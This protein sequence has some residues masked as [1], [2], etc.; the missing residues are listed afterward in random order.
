M[1]FLSQKFVAF[2]DAFKIIHYHE[3]I[4]SMEDHKTEIFEF[5]SQEN[6]TD[7]NT[8]DSSGWCPIQRAIYINNPTMT[9]RLLKLWKG[10]DLNVP[11]CSKNTPLTY[12]ISQKNVKIIEMLINFGADL[13]KEDSLYWTPLRKAIKYGNL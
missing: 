13:N 8:I 5:L 2:K 9:K 7:F 12:A 11:N 10:S 1:N 4:P 3:E 6:D